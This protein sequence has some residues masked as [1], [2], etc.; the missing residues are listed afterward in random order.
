M[1]FAGTF[2]V[3]DVTRFKAGI[4]ISLSKKEEIL[5]S[6]RENIFSVIIRV[7]YRISQEA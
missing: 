2:F 1:V 6:T 4:I 7:C 5:V 3:E